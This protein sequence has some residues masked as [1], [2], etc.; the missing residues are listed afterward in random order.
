M[1]KL[2]RRLQTLRTPTRLRIGTVCTLKVAQETECSRS[3]DAI[4]LGRRRLLFCRNFIERYCIDLFQQL[5]ERGQ[6]ADHPHIHYGG[7]SVEL[8]R[9]ILLAALRRAIDS[10]F[11]VSLRTRY[12]FQP[13]SRSGIYT[14]AQAAVLYRAAAVSYVRV[15]SSLSARKRDREGIAAVL[16]FTLPPPREAAAL[17]PFRRAGRPAVVR[18]DRS[19]LDKRAVTDGWPK[20]D[21]L[22]GRA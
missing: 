22:Y 3:A 14:Y 15:C 20:L 4:H 18:S 8:A 5:V 17:P 16:N 12:F 13:G 10:R 11:M 6:P 2:I 1:P 9:H 19:V 21:S 7:R